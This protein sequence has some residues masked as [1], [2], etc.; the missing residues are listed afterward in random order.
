MIAKLSDATLSAG[1]V[2]V[3]VAIATEADLIRVRQALRAAAERVGLGLGDSTKLVTAGSELTRN[4]LTYAVGGTGTLHVDEVRAQE[5]SGVRAV[6][7][8]RGPGIQDVSA[9]LTDGY[10][11]SGS[12]GLGLPGSKRLVEDMTIETSAAG[13]TITVVKWGR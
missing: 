6:F 11:T 10:S 8:D 9:A 2:A 3:T 12:M 7:R 5:R 4:I 13:T 1:S